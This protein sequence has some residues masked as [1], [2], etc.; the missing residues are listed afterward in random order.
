M[1]RRLRPRVTFANIVSILALFIALGGTTYAAATIGSNEIKK[2]AVLSRHIKNGQVKAKDLADNS[3]DAAKLAHNAISGAKVSDHSLT[4]SDID[5]SSLRLSNV[6]AR[7]LGGKLAAGA[8]TTSSTTPYPLAS[9]TFTQRSGE[10]VE[11]VTEVTATLARPSGSGMNTICQVAIE[12]T[13][14]GQPF[15][16]PLTSGTLSDTLAT[17]AVALR[18]TNVL[19][20]AGGAT[21]HTVSA[22]AHLVDHS[23]SGFTDACS[24]SSRLDSFA[25]DVIG[26]R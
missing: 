11:F 21:H 8:L 23:G 12:L 14:D 19:P 4:A 18:R 24:S 17:K 9:A 5:Q 15:L 3:V 16:T 20:S 7:P 2:N 6:I 25:L 1:L 22:T 13:L 26:T 10:F